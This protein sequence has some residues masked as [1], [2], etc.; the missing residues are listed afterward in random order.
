MTARGKWNCGQRPSWES[1]QTLSFPKTT[2]PSATSCWRSTK[3]A[4]AG[5]DEAHGIEGR[6][7]E[8]NLPKA[9]L[10]DATA[11]MTSTLC[12]PR[13]ADDNA[14]PQLL[15]I[16]SEIAFLADLRPLASLHPNVPGK[17]PGLLSPPSPRGRR[18]AMP[19]RPTYRSR[20]LPPI[21]VSAP[22]YVTARRIK[23]RPANGGRIGRNAP[24]RMWQSG[25]PA[26]ARHPAFLT[27]SGTLQSLP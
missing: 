8:N 25:C 4:I 10:T 7:V 23:A 13:S 1:S 14:I 18:D 22:S 17:G 20:K 26:T 6:T 27:I 16:E 3:Q 19:N 9:Y 21:T 5:I 15:M 12:T 11:S 24:A 2:R